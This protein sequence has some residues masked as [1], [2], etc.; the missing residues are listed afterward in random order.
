MYQ[1]QDTLHHESP[2]TA[3]SEPV[4]AETS[5]EEASATMHVSK[6]MKPTNAYQVLRMLPKDA[7]PAQ[8]DSAIQ[9]AFHPELT[10]LST[11]PDTLHLPGH[12]KG[13]SLKDMDT[14]QYYRES[15]FANDS[16][17]HPEL[18]GGRYGIAGDPVP[19]S[20][21]NDNLITSLL[22]GCFIMAL[23]SY[24]FSRLFILRQAKN[25]FYIPRSENIT[26]ITETTGE[27]RFQSF[28]VLQ[29]CLLLA[30]L[31]FFYTQTEVADTFILE[32]QYQLIAILFGCFVGYFLLKGFIYAFVNWIFFEKKKTEQWTKSLLFITAME[33][34]ALFPLVLLQSYFDLPMQSAVIY[35]AFVL[36]LVKI[37]TF[38][39]CFVIFFRRNGVVLQIF[40]YFC[41]LELI[42]LLILGGILVL[43]VDNL[44]INF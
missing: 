25:F 3:E 8:Q 21:R 34:I 42:P 9:A 20:I 28:L 13:K 35:M 6:P 5:E 10:H 36:I 27:F 15:F 17:F 33:G 7:T 12:D 22:L 37:L 24:S 4:V 44:K 1:Q 40:L 18:S 43:I 32:S 30:I 29:T 39:K 41:A 11:R 2:V 19:Y 14:P 23:V 16:L 26:V 31:V 38:Y